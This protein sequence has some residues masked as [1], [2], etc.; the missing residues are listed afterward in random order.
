MIKAFLRLNNGNAL[1]MN[2]H[3]IFITTAILALPGFA[4]SADGFK[5][6]YGANDPICR[7]ATKIIRKIPTADFW[8]GSWRTGFGAISWRQASYPTITAEGKHL[9]I[10][11]QYLPVDINDDGSEEILVKETALFTSIAWDWLYMFQSQQFRAAQQEQSVG[12]LL[13]SVP[14]LN[15]QNT[16]QFTNGDQATPVEVNIW[17][18]GKRSFLVLKEHFF[19]KNQKGVPSA[20]L[21]GRL[22]KYSVRHDVATNTQRLVPDMVCR[23][24]KK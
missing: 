19:A 13:P 23:I 15:P 3:L 12:R 6:L 18:R 1:Q 4:S 16:V 24:V 2:S 5:I 17:E 10:E 8:N 9:D 20:L 7:E 21:I 22:G 14:M 11:F